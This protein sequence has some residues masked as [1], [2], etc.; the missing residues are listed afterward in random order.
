MDVLIAILATLLIESLRNRRCQK[1]IYFS[2]SKETLVEQ[3]ASF[4]N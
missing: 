2:L 1:W 4:L 3:I